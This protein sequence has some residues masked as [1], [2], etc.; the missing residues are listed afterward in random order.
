MDTILNTLRE[1]LAEDPG[2]S[3]PRV[4][5]ARTVFGKGVSFMEDQIKWHYLP[6]PMQNTNRP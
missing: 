5:I 6:C 1:A 2:Q 3:A 4:V